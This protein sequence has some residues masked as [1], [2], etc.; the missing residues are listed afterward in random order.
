[1]TACWSD[2]PVI[3]A[4]AIAPNV[5]GTPHSLQPVEEHSVFDMSDITPSDTRASA[6]A[7]HS[8]QPD[9]GSSTSTKQVTDTEEDYQET[10]SALDSESAL[11]VAESPAESSSMQAAPS[12][13]LSSQ[14]D[15]F[16]W[17]ADLMSK[18]SVTDKADSM[19]AM[20]SAPSATLSDFSAVETPKGSGQTVGSGQRGPKQG[21][22][23]SYGAHR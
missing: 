1:M 8:G 23:H 7:T 21:R 15:S 19:V 13:S 22:R 5:A 18:L 14:A 9:Q 20:G 17:T 2:S 4:E 10:D 3:C 12:A 11:G 6:F 16:S